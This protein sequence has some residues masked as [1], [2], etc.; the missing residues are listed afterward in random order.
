MTADKD[1]R[2]PDNKQNEML[3]KL[4]LVATVV[5]ARRQ[6]YRGKH[7]HSV[8]QEPKSCSAQFY[9]KYIMIRLMQITRTGTKNKELTPKAGGAIPSRSTINHR[10]TPLLTT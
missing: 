3:K 9:S 6:V 2:Q 8:W 1:I 7:C 10:H 5:S 4:I